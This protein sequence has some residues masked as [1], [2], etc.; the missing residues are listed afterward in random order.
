MTGGSEMILDISD[1]SFREIFDDPS[2]YL[3]IRWD[4]RDFPKTLGDLYEHYIN[5][6][7]KM[8]P[9]ASIKDISRDCDLTIK[10]IG[11]YLNGYPDKAYRSM[12]LLMSRMI[13]S[14]VGNYFQTAIDEFRYGEENR[15]HP[16][17]LFRA[18]AVPDNQP[19]P[20]DRI[21]HTPYS[22][23]SRVSTNRYGIAG[24]PSLY[25]GT[26][27]ELCCEEIHLNPHKGFSIASRFEPDVY[28]K[29]EDKPI[30]FI[31]LAIKPQDFL[32]S[33]GDNRRRE[34]RNVNQNILSDP[35]ARGA[36]L[37]WY[38]LIAACSF[39]RVNKEDPFAAEYIIPQLLM[40]WTRSEMQATKNR[41]NQLIGI[42]YFSCSSVRASNMG[43]NYVFP[44]SG[45]QRMDKPYC[46]VLSDAFR[47][48]KPHY[49]HEYLNIN[50]CETALIRD[51]DVMHV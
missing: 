39:I 17:Y 35:R 45:A 37:S 25:L 20:R 42:R 11:H 48:T 15:Q 41:K 21:F 40:Q 2:F 28:Y 23:R 24:F 34:G 4:G 1:L 26:S 18:T 19:Y 5:K 32:E 16:L 22:M 50:D 46:P 8:Y 3:P 51:H 10:A 47:L 30:S 33:Y 14:P 49:I 36:Y 27:L 9:K 13:V 43:F 6:V 44:T 29:F 38:P 31:D 12:E 7:Q